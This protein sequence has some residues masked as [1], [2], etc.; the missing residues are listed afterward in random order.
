MVTLATVATVAL[1]VRL[2]A[3]FAL[4]GFQHP[5]TDE[6][7]VIARHMLEGRGFSYFYLGVVYL[8][9]QA[10]LPAW[11]GAASYWLTG[12]LVLVMVLQILAGT[13]LA[14][15]SAVIAGRLFG[16]WIAPLAAGILVALHPGLVV[17]NAWKFHALSFD[18]L[19]FSLALLQSFR[20][21][22]RPTTSRG[23]QLGVIL[24]LG[25][26]SRPTILVF[27]P[28]TA[29]WLLLVTP[30]EAR[31]AAARAVV[32]AGICM[33]A[34]IT[35]WT[36][37]NYLVQRQFV[38]MLTTDK[39]LL[40]RGSNPYAS[41]AGYTA[42]GRTIFSTLPTDERQ[43]LEQQ[44]NELAQAQWF[45]TRAF[46]FIRNDPAAF[47]RLFLRK[48][49]IFWSYG[50]TTGLLYPRAWFFAYLA[51]YVVAVVLGAAGTW[52]VLLSDASAKSRMFLL[53]AFMV[54]LSLLQ[55]LYYVEGR[56]RWGVEPM[57]LAMSGGG[58]AALLSR[59]RGIPGP[60]LS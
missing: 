2:V 23:L 35:P 54:A 30:V 28:L 57:L 14:V 1:T 52:H 58:V 43:D 60:D 24:G 22:E 56:H 31:R 36:I 46:R 21:A 47:A 25:L 9:Y 3:A 39:E 51:Y 38:F 5:D 11:L 10:P 15:I 59:R 50:S 44:P 27:L 40:W 41:G 8:S 29:A 4:D 32:V 26:L 33:A 45:Q 7:A 48:F 37:R 16:G 20:L 18:A 34:V 13:L 19:F 6:S 42:D 49:V 17:Y 12:S 53:G 55:S